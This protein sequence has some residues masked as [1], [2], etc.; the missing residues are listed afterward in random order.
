MVHLLVVE[1]VIKLLGHF[2]SYP[3]LIIHNSNEGQ[4][5]HNGLGYSNKSLVISN[6][7]DSRKFSKEITKRVESL[8]K[9]RVD[10]DDMIK[11]YVS[12]HN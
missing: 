6:G 7:I 11:S 2:S 12:H 10:L 4:R 5:V 3:N 1:I 8:N 9:V